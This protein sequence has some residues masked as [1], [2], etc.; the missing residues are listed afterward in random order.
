MR[1]T[2]A[3]NSEHF[4]N[5]VRQHVL[6]MVAKAKASHVGSSL[7][8]VDILSVLYCV[9]LSID[10]SKPRDSLRDRLILSKGHAAAALYATLANAGFFDPAL[11]STYCANGGTLFGHATHH[12]VPGVEVSTGSLGHGLPIGVGI[13]LGAKRE[14]KTFHTFVI[15]SDGECD[16]GSNWEGFLFAPVH[17]LNNLT[18]IIDY[19]KIQSFGRTAS[20]I[21]LEPLADKLRSFRWNVVEVDGHNHVALAETLQG[22][23]NQVNS[24]T[25]I[26]AHTI[27]GKGVSFMEDDLVWHYKYP[28]PEQLEK[29]LEHLR[30]DDA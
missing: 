9:V 4:A 18:V 15:L 12:G 1:D 20:V 10:P 16:E 13:A 27:K 30:D 2:R 7:S 25:A 24:P 6:Q 8:V 21:D 17:N 26:V 5:N 22:A 11:L 28:N 3:T 29:A 23:K 14:K 19:N